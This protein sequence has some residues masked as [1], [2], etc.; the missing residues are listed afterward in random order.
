[1]PATVLPRRAFLPINRC[2][3]PPQILGSLT[4]QRHP[5]PLKL[6]GVTDVHRQLFAALEAI[7][8]SAER[9]RRFIDYMTV[10][11]RLERLEDAGLTRASPRS[12]AKANYLRMLRGWAFDAEGRE[13]A[14]LKGWVESRFG[15]LPRF[16]RQPLRSF[17]AP[18]YLHYLEERSAGL[19][20]TNALEA[21]LDLVYA[22]AQYEL[23]RMLPGQDRI[24]LFRGVNRIAGHEVLARP[25]PR[26][27]TVLLNSLSSFSLS[28]ERACEFGDYILRCAVPTAKIFFF[29]RLL[30][31]M[32]KGEEEYVV[33]GGL[34]QVEVATL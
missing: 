6:D 33:I 22:Y 31:Q 27:E 2:N 13:G 15:L 7:A 10:R 29:S 12:R 26:C 11:F 21:Q 30:P 19:Y 16:H 3:L 14:V 24:T 25:S 34:Y 18:A 4:F 1:M 20:G 17:S 8:D 23:A 9:A 28:R 32:L 5:S